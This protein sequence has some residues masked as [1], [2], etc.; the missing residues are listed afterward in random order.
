MRLSRTPTGSRA[1]QLE[2]IFADFVEAAVAR[3]RI[4]SDVRGSL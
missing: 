3:D 4:A 2:T 1:E